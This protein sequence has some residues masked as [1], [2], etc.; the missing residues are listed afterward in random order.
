VRE[1]VGKLAARYAPSTVRTY[2]TPL[3]QILLAAAA[4]GRGWDH[5]LPS[6]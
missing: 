6:A 4:D 5:G 2:F 3:A 1:F